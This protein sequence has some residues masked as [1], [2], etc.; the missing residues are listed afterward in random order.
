[1]AL[2][3]TVGFLIGAN[4]LRP[5]GELQLKVTLYLKSISCGAEGVEFCTAQWMTEHMSQENKTLKKSET[6]KVRDGDV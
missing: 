2:L 3:I 4:I 5:S 6:K 1:M